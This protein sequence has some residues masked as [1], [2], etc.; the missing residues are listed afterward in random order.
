MHQNM[1]E[2]SRCNA[3]FHY[4]LRQQDGL[5]EAAAEQVVA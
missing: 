2:R 4:V 3:N 1:K 5:D